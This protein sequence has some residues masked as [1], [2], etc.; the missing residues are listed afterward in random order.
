MEIGHVGFLQPHCVKT[1]KR[2]VLSDMDSG[3][4]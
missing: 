4:G 2:K 3:A 1:S